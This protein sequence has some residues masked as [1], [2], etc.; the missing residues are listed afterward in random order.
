[1]TAAAPRSMSWRGGGLLNFGGLVDVLVAPVDEDEEGVV[2]GG[3]FAEQGAELL[4]ELAGGREGEAGGVV[5]VGGV[6]AGADGDDADPP[7]LGLEGLDAEEGLF[8]A[9]GAE[10]DD[11]VLAEDRGG[12]GHARDPQIIKMIVGEADG[13][14]PG[15]DEVGGHL[16][17]GAEA[18]DGADRALVG[19]HAGEG[20]LEV[21]DH[22][23]GG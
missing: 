2:I 4:G 16:G 22:E 9:A 15:V 23:V 3:G 11:A 10:R 7:T 18:V 20:G 1:M 17:G 5:E 19:E 6:A 12:L 14:D 13:G 21:G 8:A